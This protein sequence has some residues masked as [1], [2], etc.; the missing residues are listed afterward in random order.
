MTN[1]KILLDET[2]V[3]VQERVTAKRFN[4]IK[5]VAMAGDYIASRLPLNLDKEK[6]ALACW[7]HDSCKELKSSELVTEAER[8]GLAPNAFEQE[9]GHLLHGPVAAMTVKEKWNIIDQD[10]LDGIAQ[11]TLGMA[12]MSL[13]SQVVYLAD[14]L[15]ESRPADFAMPIWSELE[16][17]PYFETANK[18]ALDITFEQAELNLAK[19]MLKASDASIDHLIKVQKPIHPRAVDVRNYF[20]DKVKKASI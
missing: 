16:L 18:M 17:E 5:G 19:A 9:N 12:P 1:S 4:H 8:L 2:I 20:L 3:W 6:I 11:H 14:A 7:L 10:I 13:F 15:E